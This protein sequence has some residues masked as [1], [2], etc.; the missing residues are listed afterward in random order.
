MSVIDFS[1]IKK[2]AK[3]AVFDFFYPVVNCNRIVHDYLNRRDIES[4]MLEIIKRVE[5]NQVKYLDLFDRVGL[6]VDNLTKLQSDIEIISKRQNESLAMSKSIGAVSYAQM[7]ITKNFTELMS[8]TA[9]VFNRDD[10]LSVALEDKEHSLKKHLS[11]L[12][13][14]VVE[15]KPRPLVNGNKLSNTAAEIGLANIEF[16]LRGIRKNEGVTPYI[17][18]INKGGNFLAAYLAHRLDLH[19]KYLVKCDF[20]SDYR[21]IYCEGR[22]CMD[23]PI[24]LIDDVSRTGNTIKEVNNY[25]LSIY[26]GVKIYKFVLV[27]ATEYKSLNEFPD[28]IDYAPWFST[29]RSV[30]FPWSSKSEDSLSYSYFDD[31]EMDQV[32]GRL[33]STTD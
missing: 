7:D 6:L 15:L 26:P 4:E 3:N 17:F 8:M 33:D 22:A 30:Q 24:V 16:V 18:G 20:R 29:E 19:E 9:K 28:Y 25:I 1:E 23:A 14:R 12:I 31:L 13:S 32:V 5:N 10:I 2:T 11:T 21:K 27:V